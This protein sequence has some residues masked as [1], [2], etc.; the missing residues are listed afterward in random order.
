[1]ELSPKAASV[2]HQVRWSL[3]V[4]VQRQSWP[5]PWIPDHVVPARVLGPTGL[6]ND[7]LQSRWCGN[8]FPL[9]AVWKSEHLVPREDSESGGIEGERLFLGSIRRLPF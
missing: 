2:V 5:K 8:D 7:G 9:Y 6:R 4:R 1:M 3:A